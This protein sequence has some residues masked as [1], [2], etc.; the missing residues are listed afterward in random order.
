[1]RK[2]TVLLVVLC[3]IAVA[4]TASGSPS[5]SQ[6]QADTGRRLAGPVCIGKAKLPNLDG[7]RRGSLR[8]GRVTESLGN[9]PRRSRSLRREE[10]QVLPLGDP[11]PRRRSATGHRAAWSSR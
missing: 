4:T 6:A 11:P 7:S 9:P 1:M 3:A 8:Q 10:P 2:Y 5:S